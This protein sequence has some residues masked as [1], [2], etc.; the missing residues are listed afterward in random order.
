MIRTRKA[1]SATLTAVLKDAC[2]RLRDK[3]HPCNTTLVG[4][5]RD[6]LQPG[7]SESDLPDVWR[8]YTVFTSARNPFARAASGYHY[9]TGA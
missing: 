3:G 8:K 7:Q 1:A 9:V 2:Q 5:T 4:T 6:L